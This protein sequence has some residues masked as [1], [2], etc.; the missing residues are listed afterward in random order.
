M[1]TKRIE[2]LGRERKKAAQEKGSAKADG[3]V[4]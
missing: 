4:T 1:N 2:E 3:H